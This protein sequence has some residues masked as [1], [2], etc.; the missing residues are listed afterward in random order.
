M[1]ILLSILTLL[2]LSATAN[3][4]LCALDADVSGRSWHVFVGHSQLE[5]EGEIKCLNSDGQF[6]KVMDVYVEAEGGGFGFGFTKIE[7]AHLHSTGLGFI[8][9]ADA[10]LGDFLFVKSG[11]HVGPVGADIAASVLFRAESEASGLAI[12]FA[13]DLKT[14]KGLELS[15]LDFM[16]VTV[17]PLEDM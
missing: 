12:P 1:K 5:G 3:A 8:E 10:L 15:V 4:S 2:S 14:G 9:S 11:F 13:L 7:N 17:T 16:E 6:E